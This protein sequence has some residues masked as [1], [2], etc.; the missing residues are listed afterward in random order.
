MCARSC[1]CFV[2]RL[3]VLIRLSSPLTCK[4]LV[5]LF[6]S[7]A[8]SFLFLSFR[9]TKPYS[10]SEPP[11]S[12]HSSDK[13]VLIWF[14]CRFVMFFERIRKGLEAACQ[15]SLLNKPS[16]VCS[17]QDMS[18]LLTTSTL[19]TITKPMTLGT[20]SMNLQVSSCEKEKKKKE[21]RQQEETNAFNGF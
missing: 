21:T 7:H 3:H 16:F 18:N 4:R 17:P 2:L 15:S 9:S 1:V 12:P 11:Q 10:D 8:D 19:G 20:T 6:Y 13:T 14:V 5:F